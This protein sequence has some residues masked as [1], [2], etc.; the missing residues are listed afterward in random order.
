M[1]NKSYLTSILTN[2]IGEKI[3]LK[4]SHDYLQ[5]KYTPVC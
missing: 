5:G 1:W 4:F 3:G 2:F